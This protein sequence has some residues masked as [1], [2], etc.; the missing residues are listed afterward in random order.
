MND[1]KDEL[2]PPPWV[3]HESYVHGLRSVLLVARDIPYRHGASLHNPGDQI[4]RLIEVLSAA[5]SD[6]A[7]KKDGDT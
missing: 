7:Q 3:H 4:R 5:V 1:Y 2:A 6:A